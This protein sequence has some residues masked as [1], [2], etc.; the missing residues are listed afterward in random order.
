MYD[1]QKHIV[2]QG[3]KIQGSTFAIR[4]AAHLSKQTS[5][6][7][8]VLTF[9]GRGTAGSGGSFASTRWD[10]ERLSAALLKSHL[11]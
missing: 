2:L 4:T 5:W 1:F 6:A 3:L 11:H 9:R 8:F 7:N 10:G